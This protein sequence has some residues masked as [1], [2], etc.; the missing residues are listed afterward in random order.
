M[1]Q[2]I[3]WKAILTSWR[4]ELRPLTSTKRTH[5]LPLLS[6]NVVSVVTVLKGARKS[7]RCGIISLRAKIH[8]YATKRLFSRTFSWW[9]S[10]SF[11]QLPAAVGSLRP[12]DMLSSDF[13]ASLTNTCAGYYD[14]TY[15]TLN[16]WNSSRFFRLVPVETVSRGIQS[17]DKVYVKTSYD[18]LYL[19]K[20][21]SGLVT[22]KPWNE[23][24]KND[25]L[26]FKTYEVK[27]VEP[28]PSDGDK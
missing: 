11:Y 17:G 9:L 12:N 28:P 4:Q 6:L 22:L 27:K 24:I 5:W 14:K 25:I 10:N 3:I 1:C 21:D 23:D 18:S 7:G 15:L 19:T 2:V 13:Y 16:Y 20:T 26:V 8:M